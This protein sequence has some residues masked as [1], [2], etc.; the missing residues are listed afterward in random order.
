MKNIITSLLLAVAIIICGQMIDSNT[1]EAKDIYAG[2]TEHYKTK[3]DVWVDIDSMNVINEN[4]STGQPTKFTVVVKYTD[5]YNH[6]IPTQKWDFTNGT[7]GWVYD[8]GCNGTDGYVKNNALANNI[9]YV[10]LT[11]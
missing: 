11:N 7:R 4:K 6:Q 9:L 2:V 5:R 10:C 1:A 8:M 3:C